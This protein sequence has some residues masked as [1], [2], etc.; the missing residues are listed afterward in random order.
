V[1]QSTGVI[2][3]VGAVTLVNESVFQ[4]KPIDWRVPIATGFAAGLFALG[5]RAWPS[6]VVGLAW[7]ALITTMFVRIK[8]GTPAPIETALAFWEGTK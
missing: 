7:L 1:A 6:G 2:L 8:P 3:A 4:G 5:E